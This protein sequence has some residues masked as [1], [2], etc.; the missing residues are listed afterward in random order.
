MTSSYPKT[1]DLVQ[2]SINKLQGINIT[3]ENKN[4]QVDNRSIPHVNK[5]T[6]RVDNL[7]EMQKSSDLRRK[8]AKVRSQAKINKLE[9]HWAN[10]CLIAC[11]LLK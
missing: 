9:P 2:I 5:L 6:R 8:K 11:A 3:Y 1:K 4:H 7:T 10:N